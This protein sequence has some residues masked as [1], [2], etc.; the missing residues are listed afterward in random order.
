M[1]ETA[2]AV[3]ASDKE[4]EAEISDSDVDF[5]LSDGENEP[6]TFD[7]SSDEE[8]ETNQAEAVPKNI[9]LIGTWQ[10]M[11]NCVG[12]V[13]SLSGREPLSMKVF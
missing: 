9:T 12:E 1:C 3:F 10:T 4:S 11:K 2:T 6:I 7:Y 13:S 5:P 8:G